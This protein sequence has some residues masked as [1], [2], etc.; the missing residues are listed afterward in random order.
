MEQLLCL[1]ILLDVGGT[2]VHKAQLQLL[3]YSRGICG[4]IEA[5]ILKLHGGCL[6]RG[7]V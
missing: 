5:V 4:K 1:G 2:A 6:G 7:R 3:Y